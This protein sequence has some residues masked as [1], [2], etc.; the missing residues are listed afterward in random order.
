MQVYRVYEF[1]LGQTGKRNL[2]RL[3]PRPLFLLNRESMQCKVE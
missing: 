2:R 1:E 3:S